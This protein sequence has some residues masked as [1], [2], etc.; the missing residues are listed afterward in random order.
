MEIQRKQ[1]SFVRPIF[2]QPAV[3]SRSPGSLIDEAAIVRAET[4]KTRKIVS[5]SEHVDAVDLVQR[6][7]LDLPVQMPPRDLGRT[8]RAEALSG[9]SDPPRRSDR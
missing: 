6:Q 8:W 1:R 5:T 3:A 4:G 2:E 9:K 7:P